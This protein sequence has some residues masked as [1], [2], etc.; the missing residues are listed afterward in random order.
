MTKV[1]DGGMVVYHRPAVDDSTH[2]QTGS[3][4]HYG[5]GHDGQ[6]LAHHSTG[7]YNGPGVNHCGHGVSSFSHLL[8]ELFADCIVADGHDGLNGNA[9]V[10]VHASDRSHHMVAEYTFSNWRC[11]VQKTHYFK[12]A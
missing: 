5:T 6:P 7:G 3:G 11:I 9:A 4:A 10:V 2:A 1:F 12:L 8:H